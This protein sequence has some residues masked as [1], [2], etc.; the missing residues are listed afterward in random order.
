MPGNAVSVVSLNANNAIQTYPMTDPPLGVAF[1][2][3]QPERLVVTTKHFLLLDP[4]SGQ[5]PVLDTVAHVT[6]YTLPVPEPDLPPQIIAASLNVS[7]DG[8]HVYGLTDT[9]FF[10]YSPVDHTVQSLGYSSTP[11]LGPRTVSV[12]RDGS[13]FMAGWSLLTRARHLVVPSSPI[14]QAL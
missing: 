10:H 8:L 5:M 11:P 1:R 13:F 2:P 7:G 12:N 9:I 6:A 4:A 3:G 14:R